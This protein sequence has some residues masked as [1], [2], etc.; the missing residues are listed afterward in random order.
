MSTNNV[1]KNSVEINGQTSTNA[2]KQDQIIVL[3]AKLKSLLELG[4]NADFTMH[5]AASWH[6]YLCVVVE[7]L[8]QLEQLMVV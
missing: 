6:S 2:T 3:L 5:T 1:T 8:E 4:I 7:L